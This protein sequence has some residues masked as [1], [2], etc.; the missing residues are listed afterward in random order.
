M[1]MYAQYNTRIRNG[2]MAYWVEHLFTV[3]EIASSI[4]NGHN[5]KFLSQKSCL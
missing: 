5:N 2:D 3:Q 1:R 4:F